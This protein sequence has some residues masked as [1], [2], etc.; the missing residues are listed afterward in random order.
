MRMFTQPWNWADTVRQ[1]TNMHALRVCV[2]GLGDH[3]QLGAEPASLLCMP[4][5]RNPASSDHVGHASRS[6]PPD[7]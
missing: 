2:R 5:E 6:P 4:E 3:S 1:N 7:I